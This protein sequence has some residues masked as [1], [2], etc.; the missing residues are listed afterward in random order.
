MMKHNENP[1]TGE[2]AGSKSISRRALVASLGVAGA[3]LLLGNWAGGG[4][5]VAYASDLPPDWSSVTSFGAVGD[6]TTDDTAALQSALNGTPAGG[7][8]Y[9]PQGTYLISSQLTL[10]GKAIH[11]FATSGAVIKEASVL[12]VP[13]LK[14][15]GANGSTVTGL[16]CQGAETFASFMGLNGLFNAFLQLV[17]C[18]NVTVSRCTVFYKTYAFLLTTCQ[19]CI[20]AD[21]FVQG[22]LNVAKPN[23]GV[24]YCSCCFI[25]GGTRNIV[26]GLHGKEMGSGVLVGAESTDN[27][28]YDCYFQTMWDNGVYLS[29]GKGN[30]VHHV[31][32]NTTGG[33]GVKARGH[34]HIVSNCHIMD[35]LVG[36]TVTG[37]GT[38]PDSLGYNGY[39]TIVE[40][41]IVENCRRDGVLMNAQDGFLPRNIKIA[42]NTF[43]NIATEGGGF[44]G[45]RATVGQGTEV[46]GN[47]FINCMGS[48]GIV[49]VG[50]AT[51]PVSGLK[52][53]NNFVG[54]TNLG[55]WLAYVTN[56][57]I[58][59]NYIRDIDTYGINMRN[60]TDNV[61]AGNIGTENVTSG[62]L[63]CVSADANANNTIVDNRA[64]SMAVTR[65]ANWLQGNKPDS[66]NFLNSISAAPTS[67]GQTAIVAGA[68][69]MAVGTAS[70][71]DWKPIG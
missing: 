40:G 8:L 52:V 45:V 18:S 4:T 24:N 26:R 31:T 5:D 47:T 7:T 11:L 49:T 59:G 13:M 64:V 15:T 67:I 70:T 28:I 21:S 23:S 25:S 17:S 32:V 19:D 22:V 61:I 9:F 71:A 12:G 6:G 62:L 27:H 51:A 38:V 1:V 33:T 39:G 54:Q 42:N 53:M 41:C 16:T 34:R 35:C 65:E 66:I 63:N 69:Y 10:S 2:A 44:A 36:F 57:T 3:G 48:Y 30:L 20:V 46:T 29:S 56:S 43:I 58:S 55:I 37:N 50:T 60:C 14:L 68:I